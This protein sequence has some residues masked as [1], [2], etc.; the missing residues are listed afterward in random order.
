VVT[1]DVLQPVGQ[2][3]GDDI[4]RFDAQLPQMQGEPLAQSM[5]LSPGASAVAVDDRDGLGALLGMF[6]QQVSHDL[7]T[8]VAGLIAL[9]DT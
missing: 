6:R 1:D 9:L 4:A 7:V 3:E 2:L 5:Q 8:P